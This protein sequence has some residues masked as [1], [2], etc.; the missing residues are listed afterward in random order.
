MGSPQPLQALLAAHTPGGGHKGMSTSTYRSMSRT[1]Q[2]L[3]N[4]YSAHTQPAATHLCN[5]AASDS[6]QT[7]CTRLPGSSFDPCQVM[8]SSCTMSSATSACQGSAV[9]PPGASTSVGHVP[10][11]ATC[12]KN[13]HM[14]FTYCTRLAGH[15]DMTLWLR[16]HISQRISQCTAQQACWRGTHC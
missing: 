10:Q 13:S 14:H 12:I 11:L 5:I 6:P 4:D 2:R 15:H 1:L 9:L 7:R 16:R 8:D 3:A